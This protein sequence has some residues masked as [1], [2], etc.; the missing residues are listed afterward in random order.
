MIANPSSKALFNDP[1]TRAK[2]N[3]AAVNSIN[4]LRIL[5][6]MAYYFV[7]T[8]RFD[9]PASFVVP[10]GNF[11]N[12]FAAYAATRCGLPVAKLAIASNRNDVLTRFFESGRMKADAVQSSL[13]PSMD[14]QVSSNFERLLFD[15]CA[16]S[17][18]EVRWLMNEMR[19]KGEFSLSPAQLA[20]ARHLFTAARVDDNAT[21]ATI[22]AVYKESGYILDPHS[23]VGV[24]ATRQLAADLPEPVVCLAC[25][26]PAKFPDTI[27][28]AIGIAPA[29]PDEVAEL[30]KKPERS[31]SL[32]ADR[33]QIERFMLEV[34]G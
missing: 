32:P 5:A 25:A 15:L 34:L 13:S 3:L 6:Q 10:T 16:Q 1:A 21:L 31:T 27:K 11:G 2:F 26:H 24:A 18:A 20:M 22:A 4:W 14:I 29:L 23:A 7:A 9:K 8:S 17:G 28:R 12:I 30:L 33:H 19:E